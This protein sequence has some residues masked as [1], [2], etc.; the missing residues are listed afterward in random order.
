MGYY[1][2]AKDMLQIYHSLQHASFKYIDPNITNDIFVT[3]PLLEVLSLWV[4]LVDTAV[5]T[6]Q[7]VHEIVPR[8]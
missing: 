8:S 2:N 6:M 5:W 7:N 4:D 3:Y 1:S